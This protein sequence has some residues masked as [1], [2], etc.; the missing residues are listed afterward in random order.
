M[1]DIDYSLTKFQKRRI[2]SNLNSTIHEARKSFSEFQPIR[3]QN[4]DENENESR[5]IRRQSY[6]PIRRQE[7]ETID[8]DSEVEKVEEKST[9]KSKVEEHENRISKW[10]KERINLEI[11]RP[12][13]AQHFQNPN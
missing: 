1:E 12:I 5:P 3:R 6:E 13:R 2:L 8:E 4:Q 10:V 7:N 9:K 11:F